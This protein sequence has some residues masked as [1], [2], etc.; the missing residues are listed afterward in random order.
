MEP[1]NTWVV[2]HP[3]PTA[4][5]KTMATTERARISHS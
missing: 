4:T 1:S 3:V 2:V 5:A